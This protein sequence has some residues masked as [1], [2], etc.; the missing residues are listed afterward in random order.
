MFITNRTLNRRAVLRGAGAAVAL[1]LLDAMAPAFGAARQSPDTG[2]RRIGF[3]YMPN[4]VS[5]NFAGID[6]WTPAGEGA[7]VELSPILEPL[8]PFRERLHVISGLAQHQADAHD[9]GANGDHT[10]GTSSWLTG[11]HPKRTE[12]ADIRNGTSADQIAAARLGAETPLPSIELAI[13]LNFLAGQCENSYSCA[14]LN[15]LAW[16]SPTKP[17]PTENNPRIV[18]ERLFGDGGTPEQR[19]RQAR[20]DGSL[21]DSVL[22][23]LDRLGRRLG[24]GD[25]GRVGEY[26]DSVR[27]VER[28]IERS[29]G[30]ADAPL[31]ALDRPRGIP[32]QFGDHVRLMYALQRLAFQADLTRVVTFMLGRELNFR[33]YPE[34]GIT[35]G[36]HGLSHHGDRPEQLEKYS[37]LGAYQATLFGEFLQSLDDTPEGDGTLLDHS[38]FLYG[39]GLSNPNVHA[40]YDLPLAVIGGTG[41]LEGGRH[42]VLREET[43]MTNLLLTM[44]DQVGVHA[45]FLGDSTGR[46]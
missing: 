36:H 9:D 41:A 15:T 31:P 46:L 29:G 32:D 10:R 28:R 24:P 37:R 12:G 25:A 8:G 33:V 23:D 18:F 27:E 22:E 35:E 7:G 39:A 4:G 45:E 38:L 34:I 11:V 20:R 5:K 26:L 21:L 19:A 1:P 16:T 3:V 42:V 17:L 43:P 40:H 2:A 44:L 30:R 13:D 6:Y 14:Y